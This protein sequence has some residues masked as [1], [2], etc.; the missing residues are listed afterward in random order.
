MGKMSESEGRIKA[1]DEE[2]RI[3]SMQSG[4]G[5][6]SRSAV[7]LLY[8]NFTELIMSTYITTQKRMLRDSICVLWLGYCNYFIYVF[9]LVDNYN[10]MNRNTDIKRL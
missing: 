6:L 1:C 5:S 8:F 7:N 10:S 4:N 3:T 9:I 2:A